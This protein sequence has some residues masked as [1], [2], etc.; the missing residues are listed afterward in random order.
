MFLKLYSKYLKYI[1]RLI[2]F[3]KIDPNW[4]NRLHMT[5][6]G[7]INTLQTLKL[8]PNAYNLIHYMLLHHKMVV[9]DL[10]L[11]NMMLFDP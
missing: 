6:F 9:I 8:V 4:L 10:T 3:D 1:P 11:S 2:A 7:R 5:L